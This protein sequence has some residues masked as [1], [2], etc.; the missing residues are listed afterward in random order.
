[1]WI[2]EAQK[3]LTLSDHVKLLPVSQNGVITVG[4]RVERW[5]QATWNRQRF[6]LLPKDHP[7]SHLIMW[8]EHAKGGHLGVSASVDKVRSKYWILGI[9]RTMRGMVSRCV[10]CRIKFK[11]LC[12]QIMSPLPIERLQ[13]SPPFMNVGIDYFGPFAIRGEVQKRIRGKC[14]G[15]I[16]TCL[17]V[18]AVHVDISED[19]S[20][21]T[22]LQVFRRFASVR[23]WPKK[24]FSDN[25]TQLVGASRE[26]K[27]LVAG[28]DW[29]QIQNHGAEMGVEWK[30]SPADAPWYNGA[31]EALVKTTKRALSAAVGEN[32][33]SFSELQTCMLEAAQLVNQRP[34]G[35][36]PSSSDIG[37]Y[38]CPNDM[39]LGRVSA[40]IPQGPF[41]ERSSNRY[42]FDFIQSIV[43]VFWKRWMREVFPSLIIQTKWHTEKRNLQEGDVVLVQDI[44][45]VRGEWKMALVTKANVSADGKVRSVRLSYRTSEI[46]KKLNV[47]CRG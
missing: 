38:L 27:D 20:T 47:P 17:V 7:I 23:G 21:D 10:K 30:F 9:S 14:Y 18:R 22:F 5:M 31:S 4:G 1:M 41:K 29:Q 2:K 39:L 45:V 19:Y 24:V 34:I 26:L 8:Y 28:L 35:V 16:I 6:I 46:R 12:S 42:R 11:L 13:P 40:K 36:S 3:E 15:V 25:G 43:A 44:N 37:T 33:M 32:V